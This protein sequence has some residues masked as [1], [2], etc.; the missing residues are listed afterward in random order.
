MNKIEFIKT[1]RERFEEARKFWR[2]WR[3]Q[4]MDDYNFIAGRQWSQEDEAVLNEQKRPPITFNYSEKM[5]DAVLGAEV[6]NRQEVTY[7]PRDISDAPLAELW[8]NAAKWVRDECGAEDEESDAFRD[9]MICGLGWTNTRLSYDD[10]LEG[11]ITIERIDPLEMYPDPAAVK[12]GL[13]DRRYHYRL[14]WVDRAEV[15]RTWPNAPMTEEDDNVGGGV[16]AHGNRYNDDFEENEHD[17]H[18][19]QVQLRYYECYEYEVVY[20][21]ATQDGITDMSES[22]FKAAKSAILDAGLQF[23]RQRKKCYY[24]AFFSGDTLLEYNKSP[25]Q[26]GFQCNC[27]TGKRDRNRNTW[28]GLTRVMKDPQRWANKWLSQIM[29]IINTNAKGGLMAE[30]NAF[31]DPVKAQED[32]AKPDSITLFKEGALSMNKVKEKQIA[33]YPSG[34]DKLMEFA[35]GSLPMV[36]GINLEALGLANREQAGVLED[37]RKQ[38]AYGLL[39][40]LFDALRRYRKEQGRV[41]L[42]LINEYISDGRLVRIGGPDSQQFAQLTKTE[43]A[44]RYDVIVDQSPNAPDV[45]EK[46]WKSLEVLLPAMMKAGYP[47]P[48]EVLDYTPLPTS[49]ST[50][51]K[52]FAA[53]MDQRDAQLKEENA[54]LKEE[55]MQAKNDQQMKM[56]ELQMKQ[57]EMQVDI[58]LQQQK[59]EAELAMKER[60]LEIKLI[61]AQKEAEIEQQIMMVKGQV[62]VQQAHQQMQHDE[63]M[64]QQQAQQQER[65]FEIDTDLQK[66]QADAKIEQQKHQQ[67]AQS[68]QTKKE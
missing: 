57:Q 36:T 21:V 29:H 35:L 2:N 48:P 62:E 41:L 55:N 50:K 6:G 15:K 39:A 31:V 20:R 4:A 66:K 38:A 9:M 45:K 8:T 60:E 12:V 3:V 33:A 13:K 16:V 19:D 34:L 14:Y 51:W 25:S 49:L 11:T 47:I 67:R 52:E 63:Q 17:R 24:R 18:K 40:P 28:Y 23:V 68:A 59:Q 64:Q 22:E 37:S 7:N 44:M 65:Q 54:Q 10:D 56:A 58:Q 53:D 26:V 30:I 43:G 42:Y 46:T 1:A 5:I 61:I 32:W 27:I